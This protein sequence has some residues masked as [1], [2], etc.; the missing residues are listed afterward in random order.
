[1]TSNPTAPRTYVITGT[2]SGIGLGAKAH[3]EAAGARVIGVD[4]RDAEVIADLS[5]SEGRRGMVDAVRAIAG[6]SVDAVIACAGVAYNAG[7]EAVIRV[8]YFGAVTTLEGL[9]PLLAAGD[10]PRGVAVAS[11][12]VL[13]GSDQEVIAACLAG[14][15]E[16]AV[17]LAKLEGVDTYASSKRAL[18]RWVRRTAITPD[19]AGAGIPLNAIGPGYVKTALTDA[20]RAA[21]AAGEFASITAI[22]HEQLEP[23]G[24]GGTPQDI[25]YLL[26]WLTSPYN[27]MT[28]GQIIFIDNGSDVVLRGDDIW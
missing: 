7:A 11:R 24:G 2:A 27:T 10:R 9:R 26:D 18:A 19:W 3:L 20:M 21:V 5:T 13:R 12:A 16:R 4:I 17:S 15:E 14:D 6:S 28:T 22:P 25:A 23:L 8:N 1:V